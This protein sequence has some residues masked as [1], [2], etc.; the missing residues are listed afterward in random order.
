MNLNS[1]GLGGTSLIG[2]VDSG[3]TPV[4]G[5]EFTIIKTTGTLTGTFAGLANGQTTT[6]G[7]LTFKVTYTSNSVK[8]TRV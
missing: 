4:I 5:E 2:T 3:F 6:I 8:L 7:G 1:D